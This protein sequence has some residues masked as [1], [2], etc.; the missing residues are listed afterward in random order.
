MSTIRHLRLDPRDGFTCRDGRG[1]SPSGRAGALDLPWPSTIRGALRTAFGR[2]LEGREN[3]VFGKQDWLGRTEA[4]RLGRLLLLHGR[5]GSTHWERLW[6]HPADAVHYDGDDGLTRL[7]PQPPELPTLGR[8]EDPAREALW[9]PHLDDPRKPASLPRHW[10]DATFVGWL[11]GREVRRSELEAVPEPGRRSQSHVGIDPEKL[12]AKEEILFAEDVVEPF[13]REG[14][15]A[16]GLEVELPEQVTL[17]RATLGG[18]RRLV[19]LAALDRVLFEP[20]AELLAAFRAG[21]PGL[22]LVLVTP[23]RFE[24]GW[25]P[26]GFD[27]K[28][29]AYYGTLPGIEGELVLRAAFV[30]RPIAVSGWDLAEGKA[31]RTDRMVPPGSVFFVAR[32]DGGS[33]T[34]QDARILWLAAIGGRTEEGFGRIVPGIWTPERAA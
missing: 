22:R 11:C 25:L 8:D 10:P 21:A 7:D 20:P 31:K 2:Q 1:W 23:A 6:P 17:E 29:G 5:R 34:D 14:R 9:R 3:C 27:A 30:E 4:V 32:R 33:F 12:T 19:E 18:D 15:F 28:D 24:A 16:L 26:D 13:D